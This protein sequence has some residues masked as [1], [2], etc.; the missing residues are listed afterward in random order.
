MALI[1]STSTIQL[2]ARDL[3]IKLLAPYTAEDG[4]TAYTLEDGVTI[5]TLEN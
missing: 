1:D 5:Y 2:A 4:V 3:N